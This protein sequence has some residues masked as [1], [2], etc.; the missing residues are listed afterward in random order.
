MV[1]QA[2]AWLALFAIVIWIVW[3][4]LLVVFSWWEESGYWHG[5]WYE[6]AVQNLSQEDLQRII[7]QSS[8]NVTAETATDAEE[9]EI[10]ATS[11]WSAE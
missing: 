11:T 1:A 2:M 6:D 4:G 3:T 7:D 10:E 9:V 5:G 8:V